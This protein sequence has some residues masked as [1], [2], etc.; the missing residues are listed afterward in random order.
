MFKPPEESP[1]FSAP[2][3]KWSIFRDQPRTKLEHIQVEKP[4]DEQVELDE[5]DSR[6]KRTT[7][8]TGNF[9]KK[10]SMGIMT[11]HKRTVSE[12]D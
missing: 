12:N 11:R 3:I 10:T 2:H 6:L 1:M 7:V 8:L 9:P 5:E 4:R